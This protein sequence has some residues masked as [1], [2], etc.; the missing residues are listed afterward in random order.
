MHTGEALRGVA[1]TER[2]FPP[3][4]I[5]SLVP[6]RS[7]AARASASS[8]FRGMRSSAPTSEP[9][10]TEPGSATSSEKMIRWEVCVQMVSQ[11]APS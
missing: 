11:L 2:P 6:W 8:S 10:G 5:S 7:A 4:Q 3:K 9:P 1:R